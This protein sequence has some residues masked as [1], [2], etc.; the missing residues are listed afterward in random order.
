[1]HTDNR[2]RHVQQLRRAHLSSPE[3]HAPD[4][5]KTG[6]THLLPPMM[7]A[8]SKVHAPIGVIPT[9]SCQSH[10][11]LG[12]PLPWEQMVGV[13]SSRRLILGVLFSQKS[14][15]GV[16]L[17]QEFMITSGPHFKDPLQGKEADQGGA[18]RPR[19]A[20]FNMIPLHP[21]CLISGIN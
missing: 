2:Y 13:L 20:Q 21:Q 16:L 9:C 14:T 19:L 7:H 5:R 1:M 18:S 12:V 11:Q 4:A 10:L 15:L 3:M 8:S 6:R 17:S